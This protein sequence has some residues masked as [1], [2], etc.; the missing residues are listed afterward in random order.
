MRDDRAEFAK[1]ILDA[2][3]IPIFVVEDDL[4]VVGYNSSA[5]RMVSA[6]PFAFEGRTRSPLILEDVSELS[7]LRS[8]VPICAECKKIRDDEAYWSGVESYFARHMGVNFSHGIC[9]ACAKELHPEF[10]DEA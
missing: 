7:A 1:A 8:I 10:L 3:P 9:P 6:V 2:V 4:Q 5:G